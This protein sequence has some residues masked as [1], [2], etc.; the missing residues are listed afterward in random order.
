MTLR[1][2]TIVVKVPEIP[3]DKR[4]PEAVPNPVPAPIVPECDINLN[5]R[6]SIAIQ[7][8]LDQRPLQ[9]RVEAK[10]Y[11]FVF[12]NYGPQIRSIEDALGITEINAR[13]PKL[14]NV[15]GL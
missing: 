9:L 8:Y 15:C 5:F 4:D 7:D 14:T 10:D 12:V 11:A 2:D 6:Q 1:E 3:V 13:Y